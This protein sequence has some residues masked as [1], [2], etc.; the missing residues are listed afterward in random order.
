MKWI[1]AGG[2]MSVYE[3]DGMRLFMEKDGKLMPTGDF[4]FYIL[5]R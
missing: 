5:F 2:R 3:T 4:L 1:Q